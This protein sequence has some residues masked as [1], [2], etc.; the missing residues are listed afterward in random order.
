LYQEQRAQFVALNVE[1][2]DFL[3]NLKEKDEIIDQLKL[4]QATNSHELTEVK[5]QSEET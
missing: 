5:K 2:R 4:E 1:R 3:L